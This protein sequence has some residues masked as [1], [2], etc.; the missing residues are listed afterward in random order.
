MPCI[1]NCNNACDKYDGAFF[2]FLLKIKPCKQQHISL[3][4]FIWIKSFPHKWVMF[5]F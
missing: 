3:D 4:L 2:C 1:S 5:K